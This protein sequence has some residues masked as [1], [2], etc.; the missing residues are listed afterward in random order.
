MNKG[1]ENL[2][3][4]LVYHK[5]QSR[6][7]GVACNTEENRESKGK[8]QGAVECKPENREEIA[9]ILAYKKAHISQIQGRRTE[10]KTERSISSSETFFLHH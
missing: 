2:T 5:R 9:E 6:V 8:C 7:A 3:K 1:K 4:S 10:A